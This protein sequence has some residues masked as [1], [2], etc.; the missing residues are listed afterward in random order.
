MAQLSSRPRAF[1][2]SC[3]FGVV[4]AFLLLIGLIT[5]ST[6]VLVLSGLGGT[7]SLVSA[8]VW[9]HQLIEAWHQQQKPS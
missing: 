4:G 8:L 7:L 1:V 5:G 6:P 3:A 9:R 2:T